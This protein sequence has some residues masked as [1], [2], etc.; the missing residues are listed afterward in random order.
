MV[1]DS[2]CSTFHS[3]EQIFVF[4]TKG[5]E[6]NDETSDKND[7]GKINPFDSPV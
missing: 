1:V 3:F 4:L 5:P 6:K 2:F 7:Q